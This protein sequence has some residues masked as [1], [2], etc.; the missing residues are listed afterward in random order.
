MRVDLIDLDKVNLAKLVGRNSILS[1][2]PAASEND[3]LKNNHLYLL[4]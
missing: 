1:A 4:F 2:D 3:A